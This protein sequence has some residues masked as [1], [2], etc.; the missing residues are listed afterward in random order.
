MRSEFTGE[1]REQE[2]M[3]AEVS[4]WRGFA[5]GQRHEFIEHWHQPPYL[6]FSDPK[7]LH[8]VGI[9]PSGEVA[10]GFAVGDESDVLPEQMLDQ[11]VG[12][13]QQRRDGDV[14]P[15]GRARGGTFGAARMTWP[16]P[17]SADA[18]G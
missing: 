6:V 15:R 13:D 10:C 2:R 9:Q 16:T 14:P 18:S 8:G 17:T 1:H 3:S 4:A 12:V 11:M 5:L 7:N